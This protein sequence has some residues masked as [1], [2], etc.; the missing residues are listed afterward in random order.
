MNRRPMIVTSIAIVTAMFLISAWAWL[1][2]PAD[3]QVPIHW[4]PDGQPDGWADKTVGLLL[5]PFLASGVAALLAIIPRIEPRRT[6]IERSGKAYGAIWI[7]VMALL[8]GLHILAVS[9]AMGAAVDITRLLFVGMGVL[10]IVIG[11]YL[12]KVRSNYMAGIRTPWTLTSEVAWT[13]THRL[14]GWL[15]VIEGIVFLV[16]GLAGTTGTLLI[17]AVIGGLLVLVGVTF[18]YSYFVWKAD[19]E[20]RTQ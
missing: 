15:F 1:Q 4:G 2:L 5:L 12:P 14:G 20:R 18:A 13:K 9:V 3:A 17:T 16:L 19:P 8:G 6:N 10:F 7:G 11:N